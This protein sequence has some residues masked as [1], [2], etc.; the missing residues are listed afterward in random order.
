MRKPFYVTG[1]VSLGLTLGALVLFLGSGFVTQRACGIGATDCVPTVK[2]FD[3]YGA[4]WF[5]FMFL[6]PLI[7]VLAAWHQDKQ[8][9]L[10]RGYMITFIVINCVLG[11]IALVYLLLFG[12]HFSIQ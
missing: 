3:F 4:G 12:L 6:L 9:R 11:V 2:S 10:L 8:S 1:I 7:S 5:L